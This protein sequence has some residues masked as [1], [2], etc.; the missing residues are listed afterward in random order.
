MQFDE[1]GSDPTITATRWTGFAV[2]LVFYML[3]YRWRFDREAVRQRVETA[4]RRVRMLEEEAI[5]R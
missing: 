1:L 4:M 5:A 3:L 2:F